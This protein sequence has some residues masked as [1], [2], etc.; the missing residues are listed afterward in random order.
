MRFPTSTSDTIHSALY[1]NIVVGIATITIA[2]IL[3]ESTI[4]FSGKQLLFL[5]IG[6]V[7]TAMCFYSIRS[8]LYLLMLIV[9]VLPTQGLQR[10]V[11]IE[12]AGKNFK[13]PEIIYGLILLSWAFRILAKRAYMPEFRKNMP[14]Y[15]LF[16]II[17]ISAVADILRYGQI[18]NTIMGLKSLSYYGIYF[19]AASTITNV[20]E[21]K[22]IHNI[23]IIGAFLHSLL[24]ISMS[25]WEAHPLYQYMYAPESGRLGFHNAMCITIALALLL[26]RWFILPSGRERALCVLI[27]LP[28]L[29]AG[30]IASLWRAGWLSMVLYASVLL[31]V[32]VWKHEIKSSRVFTGIAAFGFIV[33]IMSMVLYAFGSPEQFDRLTNRIKTFRNIKTDTSVV[34]RA[35]KVKDSMPGIMEHL[36]VGAGFSTYYYDPKKG[37]YFTGI[38]FDESHTHVLRMMGLIGYTIFTWIFVW[39]IKR[40]LYIYQHL[41]DYV[42]KEF[43]MTFMAYFPCMIFYTFTCRYLVD[44][45]VIFIFAI[46]FACAGV[47]SEIISNRAVICHERDIAEL[48]YEQ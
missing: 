9:I 33:L 23:I 24:V 37:E 8:G 2:Y 41:K 40:T 18:Q 28:L 10:V 26:T 20:N 17:L 31:C 30:F 22:K 19:V 12:L 21:V 45:D 27:S 39:F 11:G 43:S 38:T 36:I 35:E 1:K 42:S 13:L 29:Y 34:Y 32:L 7:T 3:G 25:L 15:F 44:Y 46:I 47:I 14:F 6:L 16:L 4:K 5:I 48:T